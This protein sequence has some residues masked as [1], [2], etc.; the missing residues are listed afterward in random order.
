MFNL[1]LTLLGSI[2]FYYYFSAIDTIYLVSVQLNE[3]PN[4]HNI[5]IKR[6][7]WYK[8]WIFKEYTYRGRCTVWYDENHKRA[9]TI[10]EGVL[11]DLIDQYKFQQMLKNNP[12]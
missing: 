4:Y 8:P 12:K 11:S 10:M 6:K 7:L 9:G 1:F 2:V 5:V 3:L